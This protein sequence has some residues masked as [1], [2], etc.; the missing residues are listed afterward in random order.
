MWAAARATS[1]V[2]RRRRPPFRRRD[3]RRRHRAPA[4]RRRRARRA[5]RGR[6]ALHARAI[7]SATARAATSAP[8]RSRVL[9]HREQ[10]SGA[11]T[12]R[13]RNPL[14][15]T[16]RHRA[17]ADRRSEAAR[18]RTRSATARAPAAR[19]HRRRLRARS[20]ERHPRAAARGGATGVDGQLV[21]GA[22]RRSTRWRPPRDATRVIAEV[23]SY[24]EAYRR[25]GHDLDV[26]AASYV[27]ID[28][29]L[30]VCV[31]PEYHAAATS[32][33]RCS[34]R[35]AAAPCRAAG[36]GSSIPTA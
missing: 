16:R 9:V 17:G 3:R 32:R 5:A 1:L 19:R 15:A 20:R 26:Q 29:A 36:A 14:P 13:V 18:A 10:R 21:R 33:P 2:E 35:S 28:L 25:I 8:A 30:K 4:F 12:R 31:A 22:S 11:T 23:E 7:A 6:H 27:P 34:T 24:L